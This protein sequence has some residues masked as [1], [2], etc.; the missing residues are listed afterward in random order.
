MREIQIDCPHCM[1]RHGARI[2]AAVPSS[3][4]DTHGAKTSALAICNRCL[5]G[6]ILYSTVKV[7]SGAL[8]GLP[9]DLNYMPDPWNGSWAIDMSPKPR[10]PRLIAALPPKA[11][12]AFRDAEDELSRKKFRSAV[13]SYRTALER[14]LRALLPELEMKLSNGGTRRVSLNNKIQAIQKE[15]LLPQGLVDLAHRVKAFGNEIHE[16]DDP[17]EVQG[18]LASDCAHLLL[19]YLFELPAKLEAAKAELDRSETK[20]SHAASSS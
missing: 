12:A 13:G 17:D 8:P 1:A 9:I 6:V 14:A 15:K 10:G 7:P 20:P 3:G 16:D 2:V 4:Y 18:K 11:E 19:V 5:T